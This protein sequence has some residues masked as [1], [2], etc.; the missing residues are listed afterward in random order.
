MALQSLL[1]TQI[2]AGSA[3]WPESGAMAKYAVGRLEA[4][5]VDEAYVL[6]R[7]GYP[8]LTLEDWRRIACVQIAREPSSGGVLAARDRTGALRGLLLYELAPGIANGPVFQIERLIGFDLMNPRAVADALT[9]EAL[10]LAGEQGCGGL[11]LARVCEQPDQATR[12]VMEAGVGL[13]HQV[14]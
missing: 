7:L 4:E 2:N 12:L 13:L 6:V 10:R 14:F 3:M 5:E 9:A 1:L 11:S 8:D